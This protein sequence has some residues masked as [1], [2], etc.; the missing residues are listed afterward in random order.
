MWVS[1]SGVGVHV[2]LTGAIEK[3]NQEN[4]TKLR[5]VVY[6]ATRQHQQCRNKT[7]RLSLA[8]EDKVTVPYVSP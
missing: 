2:C 6:G 7:R 1:A 3:K 8:Y 4:A 5:C